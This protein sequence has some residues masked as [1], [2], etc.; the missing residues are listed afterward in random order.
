MLCCS[1]TSAPSTWRRSASPRSCQLSSEH[2]ARPVAPSGWPFEI[3]PPEGLTTRPSRRRW[4]PRLRPDVALALLGQPERLVGDQLVGAEAVVQLDHVDVVGP[5]PRLVVG[6]LGGALRH[7]GA[8]DLDRARSSKVEGMS[9]TIAWPT[10]SIACSQR[11][12]S[13]TKRSEATIAAPEPSEVGEH[14]SLVSGSWIIFARLDV[15]ERV[16]VLELGVGVVDRVLVV[17]PADPGEVVGLGAIALHV[18]AAGVAEH[19]RRGRRGLA[20]RARAN[21]AS[22]CLSIGFVRSVHLT[23]SEPFS[24]F[25]KPSARAQ[26]ASPPLTDWRAMNSALEPVEQLLLTLTIGI[27]VSPRP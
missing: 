17:L 1:A 11:S 26:S 6:L 5:E 23:P 20:A 18:L 3:S 9:V 25:S 27:P 15:L 14:C 19:L 22:A 2:W 21:I 24:I 4:S 12:C 13:S 10:I 16:L 8:D 7:V